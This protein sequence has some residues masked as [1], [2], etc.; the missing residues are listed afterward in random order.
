MFIEFGG[1]IELIIL[2]VGPQKRQQGKR[3]KGWLSGRILKGRREK[4]ERLDDTFAV[5]RI[6]STQ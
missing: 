1:K 2:V 4:T 3:W 5:E 6:D